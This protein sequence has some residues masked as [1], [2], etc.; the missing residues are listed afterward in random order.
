MDI[1]TLA[2]A[3]YVPNGFV[4][5]YSS[6]VWTERYDGTGEFV[7]TTP[8]IEEFSAKLPEDTLI[9]LLDTDVVMWVED[10]TIVENEEGETELKVTGRSMERVILG[11]RAIKGIRGKN[12]QL[13]SP[14]P[15][16]LYYGPDTAAGLLLYE[17]VIATPGAPLVS[18]I[19][20]VDAADAVFGAVVTWSCRDFTGEQRDWFVQPGEVWQQMSDMLKTGRVGLRTIRPWS[21]GKVMTFDEDGIVSIGVPDVDEGPGGDGAAE[22]IGDLRFDVYTGEDRRQEIVFDFLKGDFSDANY[23]FS[24]KRY[25]NVAYVLSSTTAADDVYVYSDGF[26]PSLGFGTS[27]RVMI[28]DPELDQILQNPDPEGDPIVMPLADYVKALE[29]K[30][31]YALARQRPVRLFDGTVQAGSKFKYRRDYNLGDLVTLRG[32]G[33]VETDVYVSEYV[34]TEDARGDFGFPTFAQLDDPEGG[35]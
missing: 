30:G 24:S 18:D 10:H 2:D 11:N 7:I 15:L 34:R 25:K 14:G 17:A 32:R 12:W 33:G 29:Q 1:V 5:G 19:F 13:P 31:R 28:V 9:S 27:R 3:Q 4:E 20:E 23:L 21:T 16:D 22:L 35:S 6:A 26:S 8:L